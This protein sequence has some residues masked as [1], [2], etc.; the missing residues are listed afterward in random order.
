MVLVTIRLEAGLLVLLSFC[1]VNDP[2]ERQVAIEFVQI[3]AI[4]EH[5]FIGDFK[6]TIIDLNG[7]ITPFDFIKQGANL[8]RFWPS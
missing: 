1:R 3:Q 5:K 6:S 2:D 4:P 7:N 8:E